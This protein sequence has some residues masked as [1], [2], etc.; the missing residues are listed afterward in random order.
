MWSVEGNVNIAKA[1]KMYIWWKPKNQ[2]FQKNFI[3]IAIYV[4]CFGK[5]KY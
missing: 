5:R 2:I 3:K 4:V 1:K